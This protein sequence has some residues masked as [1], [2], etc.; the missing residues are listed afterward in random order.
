MSNKNELKETAVEE[1]TNAVE[2]TKEMEDDRPIEEIV[3]E[4]KVE[5]TKH[6]ETKKGAV[7]KVAE[8]EECETKSTVVEKKDVIAIVDKVLAQSTRLLANFTVRSAEV[9]AMLNG[10]KDEVSKL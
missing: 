3:V 10:I 5:E 8:N 4:E 7:K 6:E 1:E 9:R 2:E